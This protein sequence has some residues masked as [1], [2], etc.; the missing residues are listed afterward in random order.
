MR[1]LTGARERRRWSSELILEI[2][3]EVAKPEHAGRI[4]AS[5][6]VRRIEVSEKPT[7]ETMK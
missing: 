6:P 2:N 4:R 1:Y 3:A 7:I 5:Y